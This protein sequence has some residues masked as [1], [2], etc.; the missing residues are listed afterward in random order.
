MFLRGN[1]SCFTKI[2]ASEKQAQGDK[3]IFPPEN[4]GSGMGRKSDSQ[5]LP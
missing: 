1:S 4:A 3:T 5:K 2:T